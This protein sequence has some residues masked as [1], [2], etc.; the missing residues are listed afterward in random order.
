M[1]SSAPE[2]MSITGTDVQMTNE[3][4]EFFNR[5]RYMM[6]E[7]VFQ[8]VRDRY[9]FSPYANVA[10]LRLADCKFYRGYYNEAIPL[11]QSFERLHPT[12]EAISYV[13]F[14]EGSCYYELMDSADRDQSNTVKM[15]DSYSRLLERFPESPFSFEAKK[16][17]REGNNLMA[18]HEYIVASWY[19]R[20]DIP[21]CAVNRLERLLMLYPE[22]DIRPKAKRLL[23]KQKAIDYTESEE[24]KILPDT[25]PWYMS[26]WPF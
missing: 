14:Q 18:E 12:N 21:K 23:E 26:L 11:Y 2:E 22:A 20:V 3:A 17:I 1:F 8:K 25:S 13:I 15:I 16:R 5:G 7:E 19:A 9:P 6:A 10:E 24:T 4:M